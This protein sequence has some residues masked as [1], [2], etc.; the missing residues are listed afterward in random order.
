MVFTVSPV[1]HLHHPPGEGVEGEGAS[2][3]DSSVY[4][5][6]LI[7]FYYFGHTPLMVDPFVSS[8]VDSLE[9]VVT[10]FLGLSHVYMT[11]G[12]GIGG[13]IWYCL[14]G[15]CFVGTFSCGM[16]VVCVVTLFGGVS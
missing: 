14:S 11:F 1:A 8:M 6:D 13:W 12:G 7:M 9:V 4:S 2:L 16:V 15:L 5:K 3:I 10:G